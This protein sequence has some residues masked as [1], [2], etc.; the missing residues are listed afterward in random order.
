ML[1]YST[2]NAE[3]A[4]NYCKCIKQDIKGPSCDNTHFITKNV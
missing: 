1:Q 4:V 3:N 2:V